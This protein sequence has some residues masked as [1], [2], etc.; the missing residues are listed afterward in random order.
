MYIRGIVA[1]N[2]TRQR[3]GPLFEI[4][5]AGILPTI[6]FSA[7]EHQLDARITPGQFVVA[8]FAPNLRL[9]HHALVSQTGHN[10]AERLRGDTCFPCKVSSN[11]NELS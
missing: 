10:D 9:L 1:V 2:A 8:W 4:I 5:S 3:Q 6:L 7:P 11:H